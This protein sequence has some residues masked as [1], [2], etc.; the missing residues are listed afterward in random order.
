MP[1]L[2]QVALAHQLDGRPEVRDVAQHLADLELDARLLAGVNHGLAVLQR[3]GH[4]L[5]AEDMLAGLRDLNGVGRVEVVR[6]G[7]DDSIHT[8]AGQHVRQALEDRDVVL[9][10][11]LGAALLEAIGPGDQLRALDGDELADEPLAHPATALQ[12]DPDFRHVLPPVR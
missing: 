8:A 11:E 9:L 7:H 6:R 12:T 4:G 3:Q 2:P 5:L 10:G 1:G